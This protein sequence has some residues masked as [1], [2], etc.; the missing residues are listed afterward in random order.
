LVDDGSYQVR[1]KS[2][3]G[4]EEITIDAPARRSFRRDA[5]VTIEH[6]WR[7]GE[8]YTSKVRSASGTVIYHV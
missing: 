8:R 7:N 3:A 6:S 5:A 2:D 1:L 4:S